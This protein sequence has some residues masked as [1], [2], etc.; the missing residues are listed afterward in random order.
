MVTMLAS[1]NAVKSANNAGI[2]LSVHVAS[3]PLL[4]RHNRVMEFGRGKTW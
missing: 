1:M 3:H 2:A 4:V